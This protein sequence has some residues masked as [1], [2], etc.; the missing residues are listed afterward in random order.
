[1]EDRP[2]LNL[3]TPPQESETAEIKKTKHTVLTPEQAADLRDYIA[4]LYEDEKISNTVVE[5][6]KSHGYPLNFLITN[7]LNEGKEHQGGRKGGG[8]TQAS[9]HLAGYLRHERNDLDTMLFDDKV[10]TSLEDQFDYGSGEKI[11]L[12]SKIDVRKLHEALNDIETEEGQ[13]IA[14]MIVD[15]F[16]P[17]P[18]DN[19]K[20]IILR[21]SEKK[22]ELGTC[23][24]SEV[25]FLHFFREGIACL[26]QEARMNIVTD[27]NDNPIMLEK[28]NIGESHSAITL[29]ECRINGVRIPKG[30]L[31]GIKYAEG[32]PT[33][34]VDKAGSK[35][36]IQDCEG[37]EFLRFTTLAV[38]PENRKRAFGEHQEFYKQNGINGYDTIS[39]GEV[40]KQ[41][42]HRLDFSLGI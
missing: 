13:L 30:S 32:V 25:Y 41:Q 21:A 27:G 20:E 26:N 29:V 23:T 11:D 4:K 28:V 31:V 24:T 22:I 10:R 33:S 2:N 7:M 35:I 17:P 1:M 42:K 16:D 8:F 15:M 40:A 3:E 36:N 9:R 12:R 14:R 39:I 6:F 37:F 34:R 18:V 38:S 5:S 19:Q